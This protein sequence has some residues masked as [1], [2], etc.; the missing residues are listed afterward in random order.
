[1]KAEELKA[2][3]LK[4]INNETAR[5][6]KEATDSYQKVIDLAFES[7]DRG[8]MFV[9]YDGFLP[10]ATQTILRQEGFSVEDT[11]SNIGLN[12]WKISWNNP[13]SM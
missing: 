1:M 4:A 12:S 8:E 5:L 9:M 7:A 10:E 3:S 11:K 6:L 13:V 2:R